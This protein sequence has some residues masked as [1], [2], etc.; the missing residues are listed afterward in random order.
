[1][2]SSYSDSDVALS[3]A[4]VL[5]YFRQPHATDSCDK[6]APKTL[7]GSPYLSDMKH[8]IFD[9]E[10][11]SGFGS[12]EST[13]VDGCEDLPHPTR[14]RLQRIFDTLYDLWS[15]ICIVTLVSCTVLVVLNLTFGQYGRIMGRNTLPVPLAHEV[16]GICTLCS[17]KFFKLMLLSAV[18]LLPC[19]SEP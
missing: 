17:S 15:F 11:Q 13:I 5:S 6:V 12:F 2:T 14:P 10:A 9:E 19:V 3:R 16:S 4:G 1:M 7:Y 18:A 8:N